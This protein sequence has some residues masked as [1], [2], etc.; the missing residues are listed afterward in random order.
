MTEKKLHFWI[1]YSNF[2]CN[3]IHNFGGVSSFAARNRQM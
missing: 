2:F 3:G 1:V